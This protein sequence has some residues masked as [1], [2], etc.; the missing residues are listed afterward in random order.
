VQLGIPAE[1]VDGQ[2]EAQQQLVADLVQQCQQQLSRV[3]CQSGAGVNVSEM[4]GGQYVCSSL[5]L[6]MMLASGWLKIRGMVHLLK[7]LCAVLFTMNGATTLS[8]NG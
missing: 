4:H 7:G 5:V 6:R 2:A 1:A 8:S 3:R